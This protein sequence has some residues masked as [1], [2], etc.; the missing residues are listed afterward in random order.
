MTGRYLRSLAAVTMIIAAMSA[1]LIMVSRRPITPIEGAVLVTQGRLCNPSGT[2][3]DAI[4]GTDCS[5]GRPLALPAEMLQEDV[6]D[7]PVLHGQFRV[8]TIGPTDGLQAIYLPKIAQ[9]AQVFINGTLVEDMGPPG[10]SPLLHW[11]S[12]VLVRVPPDLV[13]KENVIDVVVTGLRQDGARLSPFFLGPFQ[14]L[15]PRY[16]LRWWFTA[17]G[18]IAGLAFA[19]ASTLFFLG[20]A[21]VRPGNGEFAWMAVAAALS[22]I[23]ASHYT[24]MKVPLPFRWWAVLWNLAVHVYVIA[25]YKFVNLYL[26]VGRQRHERLLWVWLT[27]MVVIAVAVPVE[28]QRHFFFVLHAG[29]VA[30]ALIILANLL[31]HRRNSPGIDL[32]IL[33]PLLS[34]ILAIDLRDMLFHLWRPQ[35]FNMQI[36]Q[37]SFIV[38][39]GI[40]TYLAVSE[41]LGSLTRLEVLTHTL[42]DRIAASTQELRETHAE[43]VRAERDAALAAERQR[44]MLDLHDGVGG[45][46]VNTLAYMRANAFDDPVIK[47]ALETSLLD[48]ALVMDSLEGMDTITTPLAMLRERMEPLLHASNLDFAWNVQEEPEFVEM[49]PAN[50]LNILRIAQE[51]ITNAVKHSRARTIKVTTTRDTIVIGDD[52]IGWDTGKPKEQQAGGRGLASMHKRA[53][54]AGLTLEIEADATG[55][56]IILHRG[57]IHG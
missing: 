23:F 49:T 53:A 17:G 34:L 19:I 52:G 38:L 33:F 8:A 46:L 30:I 56:R 31:Y 51:A 50:I 37:L 24:F 1:A 18:G 6:S 5:S 10:T 21:L 11:G 41:L 20:L 36:G 39:L 16:D 42:E 22:I 48:L 57:D 43:A 13:K 26:N 47:S 54:E 9:G 25:I 12:P 4:P 35:P 32:Y 45:D 28:Y 44:I 14:V 55:T 40:A 2:A 15:Q 29:S 27:L 3:R 7:Y